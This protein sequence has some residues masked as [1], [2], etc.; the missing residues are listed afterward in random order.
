MGVFTYYPSDPSF[1]GLMVLVFPEFVGTAV[2]TVMIH[3]AQKTQWVKALVVM[4]CAMLTS[5]GLGIMF[6]YLNQT[7]RF[8]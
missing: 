3:V 1:L 6:A 8:A 2:G 7:L 4:I 5:L